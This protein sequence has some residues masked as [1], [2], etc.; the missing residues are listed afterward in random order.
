MADAKIVPMPVKRRLLARNFGPAA[1]RYNRWCADLEDGQ[2]IDEVMEGAFWVDQAPHLMGHDEKNPKG[3]GDI[4]E[5]R[6]R[7]TGLYAEFIVR[8]IGKGF[9]KVERLRMAEPAPVV[10]AENAPLT[11]RWNVGKSSHEVIRQSDKQVMA[12]GFQTRAR[13]AEWIADHLKAM[14]A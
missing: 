2:S 9:I 3:I 10:I 8:E 5:V 13:A 4:I 14:G 11:T 6:Q 12:T 7:S 1:F